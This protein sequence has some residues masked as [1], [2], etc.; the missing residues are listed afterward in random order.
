MDYIEKPKQKDRCVF[1][2]ALAQSDGPK[3][4]IVYRGRHSFVILNRFP[5]TS[6]H[7]MVVPFE[8]QPGLDGLA[9]EA[10]TEI[11]ELTTLG[12]AALKQ[13]YQPQGFNVGMN[14][15]EAAGAGIEE[16]IHVHLVP[17]WF[18]DTNFMSSL[19]DVRVLP[20]SLEDTYR[21][22]SEAWQTLDL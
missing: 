21:R 12:T 14:I 19:G 17:R 20:E 6:G 3:N 8:H 2:G 1:C 15:G 13:V 10:R 16:H 9:P 5:Y 11:M 7:L 22:I 4:L 18:G